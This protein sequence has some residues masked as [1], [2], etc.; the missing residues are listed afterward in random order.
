M[1]TELHCIS[2][3]RLC[4]QNCTA[5]LVSEDD[6]YRIAPHFLYLTGS[7]VYRIT[8]YILYRNLLQHDVVVDHPVGRAA[9]YVP[10]TRLLQQEEVHCIKVNA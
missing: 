3:I 10:T 1:F 4:L 5:F 6:V 8:P 7:Y 9:G 2:W